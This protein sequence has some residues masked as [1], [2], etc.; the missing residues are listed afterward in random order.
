I[1]GVK[2]AG[3]VTDLNL[4]Q[5]VDGVQVQLNWAYIDEGRAVLNYQTFLVND[6]G[7]RRAA[8]ADEP[9]I[10]RLSEHNGHIPDLYP[11]RH[12][13][14][15]YPKPVTVAFNLVQ[16]KAS[17]PDP[18]DTVD[19]RLEIAYDYRPHI[20]NA[21]ERIFY[22]EIRRSTFGWAKNGVRHPLPPEAI[23]FTFDFTLSIQRAVTLEPM[24]T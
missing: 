9:T 18:L 19:L 14:E 20:R 8:D 17:L 5:T 2:A 12:G 21:I 22:S 16:Q 1:D 24:L 13:H 15:S 6:D 4:V 3:L 11:N 10:L 23:A 7:T